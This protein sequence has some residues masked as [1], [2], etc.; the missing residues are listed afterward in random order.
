MECSGKVQWK[1]E[2]AF[3]ILSAHFKRLSDFPYVGFSISDLF[4]SRMDKT[5]SM[6]HDVTHFL[7]KN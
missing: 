4:D 5:N 1:C 2:V 3:V 7:F 6:V